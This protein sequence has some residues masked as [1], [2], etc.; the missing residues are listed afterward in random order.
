MI[1]LFLLIFACQNGLA[2]DDSDLRQVVNSLQVTVNE[3]SGKMMHLEN[4]VKVR[5]RLVLDEIVEK[6]FLAENH[7]FEVVE[8]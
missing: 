4:E 5:V 6:I 1:S 8:K 2:T 3:M 7:L